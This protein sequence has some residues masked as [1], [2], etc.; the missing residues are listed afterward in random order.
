VNKVLRTLEEMKSSEYDAY[1]RFYQEL[2][3]FLKEGVYQDRANREALAQL[4]L[5]ESTRTEPGKFTT[6][7]EYLKGMPADQKEI[8]YLIGENRELIEHS[9]LLEAFR[10]KGQEVLLLT[11]PVDEFV[12]QALTEFKG[13]R[14]K[15]ADKGEVDAAAVDEEKKKRFGP[16]LDFLKAKLPEVKEVRLSH[17]L[18]ESA[19]C[20]VA[21]EY[22]VGAHMERLLERMGK[23]GQVPAA[24]RRI[25]EVNPDHPAVEA[26]RALLAKDAA[27]ARLENYGRLLYDQAVVA[28]GSR[29]KDPAAF[30]RRINELMA[31]DAAS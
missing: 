12:V 21:D 26:V 14:L 13:K 2:G 31:R 15:A 19:A 5:L 4:L 9:P 25:L 23:A 22:G 10:A 1:V 3:A 17:R 28:E 16:L 11:D 24:A 8:L 20:L 6:L 29:V 30:M 27:D 7:E 18:K